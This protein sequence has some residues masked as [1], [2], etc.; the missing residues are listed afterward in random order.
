MKRYLVPAVVI[1]AVLFLLFA[2]YANF[3][4]S[5]RWIG[6]V[7]GIAGLLLLSLALVIG[8]LSK[9]RPD[10]FRPYKQYR[11]A[12][13]IAGAALAI[14]H[15]VI[16]IDIYYHFDLL[17]AFSAANKSQWGFILGAIATVVI[18]AV[19]S[20]SNKGAVKRLGYKTWKALQMLAYLAVAIVLAHFYLYEAKKGLGA[21][22]LFAL[23]FAA[24]V[25]IIR[26]I[27]L[28]AGKPARKKFEEHVS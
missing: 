22:Q 11:K 14:V 13:G 21:I 28:L 4:Y 17:T 7:T 5:L 26:G 23:G 24:A 3:D 27:A 18:A 15:L 20:T 12:F 25:I 1:A 6:K 16:F 2:F 8:P 9:F 19:V 10:V